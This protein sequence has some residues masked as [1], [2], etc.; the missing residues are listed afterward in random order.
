ML[1]A[2][3]RVDRRCKKALSALRELAGNE[4]NGQTP[5]TTVC[6]GR[7]DGAYPVSRE[8]HA[9]TREPLTNRR[10]ACS[11]HVAFAYDTVLLG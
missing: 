9:Q 3:L 11:V 1:G 4:Q 5:A 8:R 2:A 10:G 7:R 6:V